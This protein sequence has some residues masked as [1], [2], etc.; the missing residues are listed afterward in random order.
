M[1][2]SRQRRTSWTEAI[3]YRQ[4]LHRSVGDARFFLHVGSNVQRARAAW[5][6][7]GGGVGP[8]RTGCSHGWSR[9]FS[10]QHPTSGSEAILWRKVLRR[11]WGAARFVQPLNSNVQRVH[12]SW[13]DGDGRERPTRIKS[14]HGWSMVFS[15]QRSLLSGS[16]AILFRQA[17]HRSVG[18]ARFFQHV[19]KF[20]QP[21]RGGWYD[22]GGGEQHPHKVSSSKSSFKAVQ[23]SNVKPKIVR[24]TL[25]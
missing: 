21:V 16:E 18:G 4:V 9:V 22:G 17:L 6:D 23:S 11:S 1:V 12:A 2:F 5:R 19:L 3:F 8:T 20:V 13:R 7:G 14:G 24:Y 10:Q 15:R 25:I